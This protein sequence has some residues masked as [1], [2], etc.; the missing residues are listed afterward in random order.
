MKRLRDWSQYRGGLTA[1]VL[2]YMCG[3]IPCG[4]VEGLVSI[5][6]WSHS[7]GAT[8]AV[9]YTMERLKCGTCKELL[10]VPR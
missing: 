8:C 4:E 9:A 6:R 2:K 3:G 5:Q 7:R 1:E 10:P